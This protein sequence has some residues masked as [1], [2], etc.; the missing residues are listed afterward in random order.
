MF[1]IPNNIFDRLGVKP[2]VDLSDTFASGSR[3]YHVLDQRGRSSLPELILKVYEKDLYGGDQG[4]GIWSTRR[5]KT[6]DKWSSTMSHANPAKAASSASGGASIRQLQL[7]WM[8]SEQSGH[9]FFPKVLEVGEVDEMLYLLREHHPQ[10]LTS[11]T[12]TKFVPNPPTLHRI[13]SGVWTGLCFL[14]QSGVNMPHGNVK[15]SNVVIGKGPIQDA[16]IYLCDAVEET[17]ETERKRRKQEDF[18]A[19]GVLIYQIVSTDLSELSSV[20]ALVRA[21]SL[22]WSALGRYAQA[23]KELT[24]KL[25]DEVS[26]TSFNPVIAWKEWLD[27]VSPKKAGVLSV[28]LPLPAPPAGP[29][30]GGG[31]RSLEQVCKEIDELIRSEKL[32]EAIELGLRSLGLGAADEDAVLSR[33]D[34]CA[35]TLSAGDLTGSGALKLLEKAAKLGSANAAYRLGVAL[36]VVAPD[37][38]RTWLEFSV[39]RNIPDALLCLA[40]LH[41]N[42]TSLRPADPAMA[43][44]CM[45]RLLASHPSDEYYYLY[46]AMILRGKINVSESEAIAILVDCHSRG[47]FKSTDLLGQCYASGVGVE[48]DE[49]K[50]CGLFEEAWN[51]S[52]FA[53]SHYFTASNNLGVCYAT[54]FGTSKNIEKAKQYFEQGSIKKHRPSEENLARMK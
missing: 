25:L 40:R 24:I 6:G 46:A 17:Q 1:E 43:V 14:H 9:Q 36:L 7:N 18:R 12:R 15:L 54:G 5:W 29:A 27:P 11:L 35:A 49:K 45:S 52:E 8:I 20:E 31:T 28:P 38:A 34:C 39:E 37:K 30:L 47:H 23:W 19:L 42:G 48:I 51:A 41:E 50:A 16:R 2:K 32:L 53:N 3:T 26:Y 10:S 33:I 44:E 21:D 4:G 13:V 22:D